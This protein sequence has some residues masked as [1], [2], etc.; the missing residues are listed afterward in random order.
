MVRMGPA[1]PGREPTPMISVVLP[2][3][4]EREGI[5]ELVDEILTVAR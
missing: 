1:R 3:Y 2:T 5:A 4:N